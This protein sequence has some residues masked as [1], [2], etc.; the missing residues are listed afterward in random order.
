MV[1]KGPHRRNRLTSLTSSTAQSV[2]ERASKP[3]KHKSL[4]LTNSKCHCRGK[5]D[6]ANARGRKCRNHEPH[7]RVQ[8]GHGQ[9]K[10]CNILPIRMPRKN[11]SC[12]LLLS[13]RTGSATERGSSCQQEKIARRLPNSIA[14]ADLLWG[15][16][17]QRLACRRTCRRP[18]TMVPGRKATGKTKEKRAKQ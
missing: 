2:P 17:R 16:E 4:K 6:V 7:T 3:F 8:V 10:R 15:A 1:R 13:R 11:A 14:S 9:R 12:N 18:L 5:Y